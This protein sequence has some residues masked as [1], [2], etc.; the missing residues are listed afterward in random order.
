MK[1]IIISLLLMAA[2][3]AMFAQ[4][5]VFSGGN[6]SLKT[7]ANN[8]YAYLYDEKADIRIKS[9]SGFSYKVFPDSSNEFINITYSL[10]TEESLSIELVDLFGKKIKTILPKQDQ[11]AGNYAL[12]V[13]VSEFSIGSY[14]LTISSSNQTRIEKIIINK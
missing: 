11:Q 9:E 12:Q 3:V 14:F 1:K 6:V 7:S 5:K 8:P 10:D 2:P 13:P 4:L